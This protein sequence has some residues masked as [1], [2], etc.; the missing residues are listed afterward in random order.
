[1]AVETE[2]RMISAD[3]FSYLM[4]EAMLS[5]TLGIGI[6]HPIRVFSLAG[7]GLDEAKF[8]NELEPT[9]SLLSWDP[10]DVKREQVAFLAE[11]FFHEKSRLDMFLADH[12]AGVTTLEAVGDLI[13]QLSHDE[14][15]AFERIRPRR[16]R[17]ISRFVLER[18]RS[19]NDWAVKPLRVGRTFTQKAGSAREN[20][21]R[22]LQRVFDETSPAVTARDDFRDLLK[23]LA[24]MVREVRPPVRGIEMTMHQVSIFA[25]ATDEG[26]NSPEGIHQDGADYIVS[27]LVIER[28]GVLGG[29]SIVYG[30]DKK[31]EYLR[32]TLVPGTGL[33]QA[34]KGSPLWHDVTPIKDDPATPPLYGKRSI[35]GFD[36]K[37]VREE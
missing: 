12:Y 20:D 36:M 26:D 3:R 30:P 22:V 18:G 31:T 11:R 4:T 29:E 17:S 6:G 34:D 23:C 28:D 2:E 9:F 15:W 5:Q 32:I 21:E 25:D 13:V 10:Y 16:K 19:L 27:A 1:M 33:F 8:L 7:C 37:V 24:E 35:L 14:R